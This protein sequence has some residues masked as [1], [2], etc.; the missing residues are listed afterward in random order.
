MVGSGFPEGVRQLPKLLLFFN[1][2]T[3]FCMKMKESGPPGG[4]SLT[5][6]LDP[7]MLIVWECTSCSCTYRDRQEAG[8]L[9]LLRRGH[10]QPVP[11][12][13]EH[14]VLWGSLR[15]CSLNKRGL[16]LIFVHNNGVFSTEMHYV[17]VTGQK[18]RTECT[19]ITAYYSFQ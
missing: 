7:P 8:G 13:H 4:A 9:W 16:P 5:P 18:C 10:G 6:P 19:T 12:N 3:K 17:T 14:H 15:K 2:L 11:H 1:F